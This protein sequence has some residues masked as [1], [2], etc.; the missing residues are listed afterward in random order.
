[1]ENWTR[2]PFLDD[3]RRLEAEGRIPWDA[4]HVH[5]RVSPEYDKPHLLV[6][7]AEPLPRWPV[8]E[9]YATLR[10]PLL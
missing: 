5:Y 7:S 10:D 9:S 1:M 2:H 3:I 6:A 4:V 8:L